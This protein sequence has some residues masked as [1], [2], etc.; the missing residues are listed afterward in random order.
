MI[1]P[2]FEILDA[3]HLSNY[4][5]EFLTLLHRQPTFGNEVFDQ[6]Q[7]G[8]SQPLFVGFQDLFEL[9]IPR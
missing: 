1:C 5:E 7:I 4:I 8:R 9:Q 3:G 6:G 2:G